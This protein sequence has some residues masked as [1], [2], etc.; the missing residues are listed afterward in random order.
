LAL[1]HQ[2]LAEDVQQTEDGQQQVTMT[3]H[4]AFQ[5]PSSMM[6]RQTEGME[7]QHHSG[8]GA[9]HM[10]AMFKAL[11]LNGDGMVTGAEVKASMKKTNFKIPQE[12]VDNVD[13]NP[14]G[15]I[16]YKMFS[17]A[18][19]FAAEHRHAPQQKQEKKAQKHQTHHHHH[20]KHRAN[21]HAHRHEASKQHELLEVNE[22]PAPDT[23]VTCG[24]HKAATCAACVTTNAQGETVFDHGSEWCNGDCV[25]HEGQCH[26]AGTV[27]VDANAAAPTSQGHATTA[28]PDIL[29][30]NI[31]AEDEKII[32]NAAEDA[33]K[34]EETEAAEK[35]E[36][37]DKGMDMGKFW[38]V[39]II[40]FSVILGICCIVSLV[41]GFVFVFMGTPAPEKE[42]LV[43]EG[44][45]GEGEEGEGEE[46]EEAV[47]AS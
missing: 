22:D 46:A 33:I 38:L 45:E 10:K 16:T 13:K 35:A 3:A 18:A 12:F 17:K 11:D 28:Q 26:K 14:D 44:E 23:R 7:K 32:K 8:H 6:R 47:E 42:G 31:T 2:G 29:N 39:I 4:G 34:E 40:L 37:K 30:Q 24:G 25:Y 36:D 21:V 1:V 43:D 20:A 41:T 19:H 5:K 9:P 27:T 15:G